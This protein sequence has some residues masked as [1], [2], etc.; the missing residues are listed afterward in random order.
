MSEHSATN[1]RANSASLSV[2]FMRVWRGLH[3]K[4]LFG[5]L[6][7]AWVAM[8]HF[9]GNSTFGYIDSPSLF[10]WMYICYDNKGSDDGYGMLIPFIVFFLLWGKRD[11]FLA[12]PGKPWAPAIGLLLIAVLI[13]LLGY[14]MQQPRVSIVAFF[15]GLYALLGVVWGRNW[16]KVAFMPFSMF[17]FCEP[18][19][20]LEVIKHLTMPLQLLASAISAW[21]AHGVLGFEVSRQGTHILDSFGVVRYEVS[22]GCSG[23]RSLISLFVLM[24]AFGMITYRSPWRRLALMLISAPMALFCNV[25]RLVS[26]ITAGEVWGAKASEVVHEYS[27]FFTYALAL[28]CMLA[29]SRWWSEKPVP[30]PVALSNA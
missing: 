2:E 18:M 19:S 26:V 22:E 8:F 25:L 12:L 24:T 7:I 14:A 27:G 16:L 9:L 4:E 17:V 23:I 21:V 5:G 15:F 20:S 10:Q 1:E 6:L 13:H 11:E 3:D 28:A 30:E 29:L